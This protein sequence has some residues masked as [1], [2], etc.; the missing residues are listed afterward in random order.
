MPSLTPDSTTQPAADAGI[1]APVAVVEAPAHHK[2]GPSSLKN[3]EICPGWKNDQSGDKTAADEGTKMHLAFEKKDLTGLDP[4]Q[5]E[6]VTKC[7][8]YAASLEKGA[9]VVLREARLIVLGGQTFGTAD[10]VILRRL[11]NGKLHIDVLDEKYG[12]KEV[13]DAETNRQGFAYVIGAFDLPGDWFKAESCTVH[14]LTPRRD[15]VST[16]TFFRK[17]LPRLSLTVSNIIARAEHYSKSGETDATRDSSMLQLTED[18][19]TW[20]GRKATCPKML[21]YGLAHAKKYAPLEIA[22][23]THSSTITDGAKMAQLYTASKILEKMVDSVKKHVIAFSR[24][25]EM[26]G[27]SLRERK[28]PVKINN[29]VLAW[30]ELLKVFEIDLAASPDAAA[31]LA[32]LIGS[33]GDFSYA[34][35]LKLASSKAAKGQKTE[36]AKQLWITLSNAECVYAGEPTTYLQRNKETDVAIE[37]SAVPVLLSHTSETREAE[38]PAERLDDRVKAVEQKVESTSC[39]TGPAVD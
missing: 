20:C 26:P 10:L 28:C 34:D 16:H 4:E 21:A 2:F 29:V 37:V 18:N 13:D 9:L 27:Y 25:N 36:A 30:P 31:K 11:K 39:V 5:A 7:L 33:C 19:C 8:N 24:E 12:R 14:F 1:A 3:R 23:E 17:D 22:E 6:Q 15:E 35:V 38:T 32:E